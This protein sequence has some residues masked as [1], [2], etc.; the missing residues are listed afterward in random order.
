MRNPVAHPLDPLNG[1]EF[2]AVA[3]ILQREH[4]VVAGAGGPAT[5]NLGWRFASIELAEPGKTELQAFDDGG[6]TWFGF[7]DRNPSLDVVATPPDMCHTPS[8]SAHH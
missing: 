1:D 2:R 7:F 8:T 3:S 6:P 5:S 4:G